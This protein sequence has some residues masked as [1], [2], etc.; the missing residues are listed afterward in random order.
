[1]RLIDADALREA[2]ENE[3][4]NAFG[5][6]M[7]KAMINKAKTVMIPAKA[8]ILTVAEL[9]KLPRTSGD[10]I[11]VM[12]EERTIFNEY[13]DTSVFSWIGSNLAW[14]QYQDTLRSAKQGKTWYVYGKSLRFWSARPTDEQREAAA[15]DE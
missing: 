9:R 6:G 7:V 3:P 8:H 13:V 15:W 14:E 10:A 11:P 5:I 2:F 4:F 1:M 12:R